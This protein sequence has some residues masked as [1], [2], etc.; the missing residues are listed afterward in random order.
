M[1]QGS[2]AAGGG[3][4]GWRPRPFGLVGAGSGVGVGR[5]GENL[6][7]K[8]K[9]SIEHPVPCP[10]RSILTPCYV[11]KVPPLYREA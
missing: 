9:N 3:A 1:G 6:R 7:G 11:L 5:R 10:T 2:H 8:K 4:P